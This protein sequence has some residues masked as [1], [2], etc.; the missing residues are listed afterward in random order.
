MYQVFKA[1]H[2]HMDEWKELARFVLML[3]GIAIIVFIFGLMKGGY[4]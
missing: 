3:L 4:Q 2:H 1:E